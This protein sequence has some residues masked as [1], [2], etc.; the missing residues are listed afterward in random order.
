MKNI[1]TK[2][3]HLVL[4]LFL[5]TFSNKIF[6]TLTPGD[7]AIIG[8]KGEPLGE[9]INSSFEFTFIL[10]TNIPANEPTISFTDRGWIN[11]AFSTKTLADGIIKWTPTQAYPAGTI[12][13]VTVNGAVNSAGPQVPPSFTSTNA[14]FTAQTTLNTGWNNTNPN[15]GN[16]IVSSS[17]GD[18]ILVYQGTELAPTFIYG[19]TNTASETVHPTPATWASPGVANAATNSELPA[20]LTNGTTAVAHTND[21][22]TPTAQ[23]RNATNGWSLDNLVFTGPFVGN[24]AAMLTNIGTLTNW[25]GSEGA[26]TTI[27]ITPGGGSIPTTLAVSNIVVTD[28]SSNAITNGGPASAGNNT[29][30]G[31]VCVNGGQVSKTYTIKNAGFADLTLTGTP[32]VV[33]GGAGASSYS[34]TL[35]PTSPIVSGGSITVTVMFDPTSATNLL[36]TLSIANND[37]TKNPFVINISGNGASPDATISAATTVCQ[38]SPLTLSAPNVAGNTYAWAGNGVAAT[39]TFINNAIPVANGGLTYTVTVTDAIGCTA[40]GSKTVT[41]YVQPVVDAGNTQTICKGETATLKATCIMNVNAFLNG[42]SQVPSNASTAT[43]LVYGTF[44]PITNQLNITITYTGLTGGNPTGAHIHGP[45]AVGINAGV[46]VTLS[47]FPAATSGTF[48]YNG[49]L[50]PTDAASLMAGNTYVNIHNATFGGGEIRGQ[51]S[52]SC[53]STYTWNPGT[54]VGQTVVVSPAATQIYSLVLS[55]TATGC[56]SIPA[57]T[58]VNVNPVTLPSI[59]STVLTRTIIGNTLFKNN[60]E[61]M[62]KVAPG[63]ASP[64]AGN[65]TVTEFVESTTFPYLK[66]HYEITPA[67]QGS[68]VITLYYTQADFNAYNAIATNLLKFPTGPSDNAGIANIQIIKYSGVSSPNDGLPA[69][70]PVQT[71]TIIASPLITFNAASGL[72]ELTFDVGSFSGFF[73]TTASNPLPVN[74]VS[75]TGKATEKGNLLT[76]KTANEKGFDRFEV[77][78]SPLAPG[79]GI[80]SQKFEKIGQITGNASENY[81]FL[82]TNALSRG[83]GATPA[84]GSGGLYRLKMI[85]LDG[86]YSYSKII[87]IDNKVENAIVGNFYPNPTA[88]KVYVD[89]NTI[90]KGSWKITTF[91]V[92]GKV[93]NTQSKILQKGLNKV[94]L[95]KLTFGVNFVSFENGAFNVIRKVVKE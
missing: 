69:H 64:V 71:P 28:A 1:F 47:G 67:I 25:N 13:K 16:T 36:A 14:N 39:N 53:A 42:T 72:W 21:A 94:D 4:L 66:R 12:I 76:W 41:V 80:S 92:S 78:K 20:G 59:A 83:W 40:T 29:S 57:T 55:N 43:G 79:G 85:D 7:I 81:E 37:A 3:L 95:E 32:K 54:L 70:Y 75:F 22:N 5:F 82:D 60:C 31:T 9:A 89:I 88:G 86:K 56:A 35:Q 90:E 63:G 19:F 51:L 44:N 68:G 34:V 10:L 24:K 30:F 17:G 91:D 8:Y 18:Q 50:T 62:A 46:L 74:L 73:T 84:L 49:P 87:A 6:A 58:T 27:N 48:S 33:V 93:I 15:P 2:K 11:N 65:V 38:G 61:Y 26:P 77:E 45:A 23:T 52:A